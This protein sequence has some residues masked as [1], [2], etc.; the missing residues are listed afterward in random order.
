MEPTTLRIT[1]RVHG[2]RADDDCRLDC[3]VLMD[4]GPTE[5]SPQADAHMKGAF[6]LEEASRATGVLCQLALGSGFRL[7][8]DL[9]SRADVPG[10][11]PVVVSAVSELD[12]VMRLLVEYARHETLYPFSIWG[13]EARHERATHRAIEAF[14]S[15]RMD[16]ALFERI[17][18]LQSFRIALFQWSLTITVNC[19][20]LDRTI[21]WA[22]LAGGEPG[23]LVSWAPLSGPG[24][25]Q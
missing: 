10:Q 1:A 12:P 17:L 18:A 2:P 7:R 25:K 16:G 3:A 15:L 6:I 14:Q 22:Q 20:D 8:F 23:P 21:T 4:L 11:W 19:A 13:I 9:P 5:E 24:D